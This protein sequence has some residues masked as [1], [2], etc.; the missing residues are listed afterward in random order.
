VELILRNF[1]VSNEL[2]FISIEK[3]HPK[4]RYALGRADIDAA[5]L[6]FALM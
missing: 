4:Q 3:Y 1:P 5:G 2:G 6:H